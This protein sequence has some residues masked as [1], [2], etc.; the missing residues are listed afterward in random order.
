MFRPLDVQSTI[1]KSSGFHIGLSRVKFL[2]YQVVVG[3][4]GLSMISYYS[5]REGGTPPTMNAQDSIA[6]MKCLTC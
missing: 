3:G 1:K 6:I 5:F 4:H 2:S